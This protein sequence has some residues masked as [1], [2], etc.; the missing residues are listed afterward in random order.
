MGVRQAGN[1]VLTAGF[2][3]F[4][5]IA[6]DTAA[7]R[8][9]HDWLRKSFESTGVVVDCP[10]LG[11]NGLVQPLIEAIRAIRSTLLVVVIAC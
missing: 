11:R 6:K 10:G 7:R 4:P 1:T 5:K 8:K 3:R 2:S 9:H